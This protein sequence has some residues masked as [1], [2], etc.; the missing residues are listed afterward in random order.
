[1]I[2][3]EILNLNKELP[4][5]VNLVAVSKFNPVEAIQEAYDAGQRLFGEN[6][7]QE[8]F[9]KYPQLPKDIK[10]HFIGKLQTN[11]LKMVVPF[12]DLIQSVDSEKLLREINKFALKNNLKARCL[13]EVHIAR[14]ESKQGFSEGELYN[15]LDDII[16]NPLNGVEICGLMGMATFTDNM[17]Q[18][19]CEFA[20]LKQ[21]FDN[22]KIKY[23]S[24]FPNFTELS[25]GMSGDY[26]LAIKN[27]S[28]IVRIG[29]RIF[30]SIHYNV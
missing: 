27:G 2:K 16:A 10:W 5:N 8:L 7:P 17:E 20:Q 22:V 23:S 4:P 9:A 25:M 14:E 18:V 19:N 29:T 30:G 26:E 24:S 28:T 21:I 11:K 13:L 6:R 1:M 15:I 12:A 3:E